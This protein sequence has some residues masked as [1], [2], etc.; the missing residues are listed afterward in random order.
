MGYNFDNTSNQLL[1]NGASHD[2][3]TSTSTS[4]SISS[5]KHSS[6]SAAAAQRKSAVRK[7]APS[8][9]D[10]RLSV[11]RMSVLLSSRQTV[12]L[13]RALDIEA[14]REKRRSVRT[15]GQV[16]SLGLQSLLQ[17]PA[18]AGSAS[19]GAATGS[20]SP[21][22]TAS[23]SSATSLRI[24]SATTAASSAAAS[25]PPTAALPPLLSPRTSV[26]VEEEFAFVTEDGDWAVEDEADTSVLNAHDMFLMYRENDIY[27]YNT[28]FVRDPDPREAD[29]SHR[30]VESDFLPHINFFADT[31]TEE[32]SASGGVGMG[33]VL[34]SIR[35]TPDPSGYR[36][37]LRTAE[38]DESFWLSEGELKGKALKKFRNQNKLIRGSTFVEACAKKLHNLSRFRRVKKEP[39]FSGKLAELEHLLKIQAYKF[40]VVYARAG[41]TSAD[42]IL[43]NEL[44]QIPPERAELFNR[45]LSM[46]GER[47]T[48]RGWKG[49]RGDLDVTG[50]TTGT[51]SIYA[52]WKDRPVMFQ[53]L[54][55]I[56]EHASRRT[57]TGNDICVIVY[58]DGGWLC[59][60]TYAFV[61]VCV[62]VRT[63]LCVCVC[64]CVRTYLCVCVCV[65][66]YICV[67]VF[68]CKCEI[69]VCFS[70][71]IHCWLFVHWCASY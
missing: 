45:F 59:V 33:L 46:L 19:P 48:L 29:P 39:D 40:A 71:C 47:V 2:H 55:W 66:A 30:L 6:S 56:T 7:L 10:G 50:D 54:P 18:Q 51:H 25:P 44:H 31:H 22:S 52:E 21:A 27:V 38:E 36:V 60:C 13:S 9:K 37:L 5:T 61:C 35:R 15:R 57:K 4:T 20:A 23:V 65:C 3:T 16:R 26:S 1:A 42:E 62:C 12:D 43:A 53:V 70:R 34:G 63:H 32:E 8:A 67:R 49:Y 41:Q 17:H 24:P 68:L 14:H 64:V 11:A 28:D 58:Q 69:F